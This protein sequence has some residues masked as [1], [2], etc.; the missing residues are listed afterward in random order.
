MKTKYTI[1]FEYMDG[2]TLEVDI[3]QGEMEKF[4]NC[5]SRGEIY[6]NTEKRSG[7]WIAI[8]KV[9]HFSV[10]EGEIEEEA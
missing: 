7:V 4:S 5:L 1:N 8:D 2:K 6:F 9:R 3:H 10:K